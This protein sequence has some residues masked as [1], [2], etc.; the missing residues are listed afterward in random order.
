MTSW[1][2]SFPQLSDSLLRAL[3]RSIDNGFRSFTRSYGDL[4]EGFFSP[5]TKPLARQWCL[6]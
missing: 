5:W 1:L 2:T 6:W 3:Q 4:I